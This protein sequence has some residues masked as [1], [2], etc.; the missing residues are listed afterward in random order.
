M[1][2][3]DDRIM[4]Q[5]YESEVAGLYTRLRSNYDFMYAKLGDG[6]LDLIA[7]MSREYGLSVAERAKKSLKDNDLK[8]VAAYLIRI[9]ETVN[10]DKRDKIEIV[11]EG[12]NKIVIRVREC[13][14]HF[15]NPAMCRAHTSMEKAVVEQL[16]P[17]LKYNIP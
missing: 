2:I 13:P 9:F 14:L 4:K 8:S 1:Q 5:E 3:K 7:D 16:N 12:D 15:E 11:E 17:K 6:G 10:W